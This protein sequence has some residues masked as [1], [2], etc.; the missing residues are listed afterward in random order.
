MTRRDREILDLLPVAEAE[1]TWWARVFRQEAEEMV[2]AAAVALVEAYDSY[3]G[4]GDLSGWCRRSIRTSLWKMIR[5]TIR[6]DRR[7]C[8][9][10]R[11]PRFER[12]GDEDDPEDDQGDPIE[13][14]PSSED[15]TWVH[16]QNRCEAEV[17]CADL[18]LELDVAHRAGAISFTER[19]MLVAK[20]FG[21]SDWQ[22][23]ELRLSSRRSTSRAI[24]EA[25]RKLREWARER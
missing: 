1:G 6:D 12:R 10:A 20:L 19:D 21:A 15:V 7:R 16:G 2:G 14:H 25:R 24:A 3:P 23:A 13:Q 11:R 8:L 5:S 18:L 9:A 4:E 17:H 22:I